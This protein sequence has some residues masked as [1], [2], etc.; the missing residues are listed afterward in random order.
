MYMNFVFCYGKTLK[1]VQNNLLFKII[2]S[3]IEYVGHKNLK[4]DL[5]KFKKVAKNLQVF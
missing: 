4:V 3:V 1:Y 2:S 5:R